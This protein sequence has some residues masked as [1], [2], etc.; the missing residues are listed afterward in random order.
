MTRIAFW[1]LAIAALLILLPALIDTAFHNRP[2][3]GLY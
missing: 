3:T 1:F 2:W